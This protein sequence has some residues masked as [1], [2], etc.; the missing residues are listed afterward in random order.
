[1]VTRAQT[2]AVVA[3][4][5]VGAIV[6]ALGVPAVLALPPRRT[7]TLSRHG[8]TNTISRTVSVA[9]A[10]VLAAVL[11]SEAAEAVAVMGDGVT[12]ALART[13]IQTRED[14]AVVR[15]ETRSASAESV[16]ASAVSSAEVGALF[17]FARGPL[18]PLRATARPVETVAVHA[19]ITQLN[20]A[21]LTNP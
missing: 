6:W 1:M 4:S 3:L 18:P 21:A 13:Q 7:Q 16:V 15:E 8:I 11:A 14:G 19:P 17:D 2:R 20:V 5:V 12:L 9:R 10:N